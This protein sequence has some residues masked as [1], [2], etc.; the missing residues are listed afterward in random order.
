MTMIVNVINRVPSDRFLCYMVLKLI[1][2]ILGKWVLNNKVEG[3][4]ISDSKFVKYNC[5]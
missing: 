1:K 4:L 2:K 3:S 5:K